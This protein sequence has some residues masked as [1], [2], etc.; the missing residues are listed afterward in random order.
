MNRTD[1]SA[2]TPLSSRVLHV[3]VR[4]TL[5]LAFA[6]PIVAAAATP[7]G[8]VPPV[9]PLPV[10]C[11]AGVCG[12]S[13]PVWA[14]NGGATLT[15]PTPTTMTVNQ[16]VQNVLLNWASFNIGKG[17]LRQFQSAEL[18]RGCGQSNLAARPEPNL[19][20]PHRQRHRLPAESKRL[21]I[22]SGEHGQRRWPR[23]FESRVKSVGGPQCLWSRRIGFAGFAGF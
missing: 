2:Q 22:W 23:R 13:A 5:A 9:Q 8:Y 20:I 17:V 19:G 15:M 1:H 12:A 18:K 6:V 3:A 7:V 4:A 11:A 16:S 21:F 14:P 10:P